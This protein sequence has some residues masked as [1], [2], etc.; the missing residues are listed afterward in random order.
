MAVVA[1]S[2]N[3]SVVAY[4]LGAVH[5]AAANRGAP[6]LN[7]SLRQSHNVNEEQLIRTF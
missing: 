3:E 2:R 7:S 5:I 6:H 4:S 1:G